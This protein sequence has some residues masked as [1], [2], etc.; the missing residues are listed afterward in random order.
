MASAGEAQWW[1]GYGAQFDAAGRYEAAFDAFARGNA[2]RRASL[3]PQGYLQAV[4]RTLNANMAFCTPAFLHE[5]QGR[6]HPS[7]APIFII[8]MPRSGSTLIEQILIAHRHVEG[9][10]EC[11]AIHEAIAGRAP[12]Q[13][14]TPDHFRRLGARY[15]DALRARGWQGSRRVVDKTLANYLAAPLLRLIFPR[16]TIIHATR[17][18]LDTCLSIFMRNFDELNH[19]GFDLTDIAA[20]YLRYRRVMDRWQALMPG[21]IVEVEHGA[22]VEA[23]EAAMRRL[24][25]AV[26]LAWD[27]SCLDLHLARRRALGGA[28][29]EVR[30]PLHRAGLGRWRNYRHQLAPLIEALGPEGGTDPSQSQSPAH[31]GFPPG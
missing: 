27:P 1:F 13:V 3:D 15:L 18:P 24:I 10:G 25:A 21:Q 11:N 8:G 30:R 7:R 9:F 17:H 31:P 5:H 29:E 2:L 12:F 28:G 26:G 4:D 20:D 16:S 19:A 6:G 22:L 14:D 23:P